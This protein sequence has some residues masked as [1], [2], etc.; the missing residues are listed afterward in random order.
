[1]LSGSISSASIRWKIRMVN[2]S[3]ALSVNCHMDDCLVGA[4][5]RLRDFFDFARFGRE[6]DGSL[7]CTGDKGSFIDAFVG[8]LTD[9]TE[10]WLRRCDFLRARGD[11]GNGS[12]GFG[13]LASSWSGRIA[14]VKD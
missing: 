6:L 3:F 5:G 9:L 11:G 12:F 14:S 7:A 1:V 4:G 8:D 2:K 13:N 10:P